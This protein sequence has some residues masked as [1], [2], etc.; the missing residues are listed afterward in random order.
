MSIDT[1]TDLIQAINR[2]VTGVRKAP[3]MASYP[4]K[5]DTADLPLILTWQGEATWHHEGLGGG[6]RRQ[7]R[8]YH[9]LGFI[10]PLGQSELPTRALAATR[11]LQAI[12]DRWLTVDQVNGDPVALA[13]PPTYQVTAQASSG[14]PHSDTGI[15]SDLSIGGVAFHGFRIRLRVREIW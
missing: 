6:K 9:I 3:P 2:S 10:E 14:S 15:V 7:D 1:T 12:I 11:L 5:A 4:L 8:I 13:D